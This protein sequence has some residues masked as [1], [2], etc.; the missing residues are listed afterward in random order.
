MDLQA[1]SLGM[2]TIWVVLT[3]AM[4]FLMEGGFA[5][6]EA[7]FVRSKNNVSIIMKVFV[8]MVFGVLAFFAVGFGIMFGVDKLGLFGTNGFALQ[9][10]LEHLGLSVPSEAFWLFQAAFVVAAISIVSGAIAERMNFKAYILFAVV[11][12]AVIYPLSGHWVWGIDGWL[13]KLGMKDFAGS[14]AIHAMAGFAALAAARLVGAR[15]GKFNEDGTVNVIAPSNLPL[16]AMGTFVLWFG[17]F[18]FNAGSTLN[19][20]ASNIGSIAS[21]TLLAS[22]AGG[23]SAM[24]YTLFKTGKADPAFTINGVLAGLVAI[25]AGCAFVGPF[26]ALVIGAFAGVLMIWAT[27][28]VDRMK[29]D[30]PVGAVAVHGFNGAFGAIAVG[31]FA[32]DGGLLT[33]GGWNLLGAQVLGTVVVSVWGY[34]ATAGT[35]KLIDKVVSIRVSV[36]E[37]LAGLDLSYHGTAAYS[38]LNADMPAFPLEVPQIQQGKGSE[39]VRV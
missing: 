22:A 14:A 28:W 19:A 26:S 4:I 13:A 25:T 21:V 6:L 29:V 3:A 39:A 11:M 27:G 20:T 10:S 30:D 24:L 36:E 2:N 35:L 5:L 37:E 17:W 16:A 38:E 33:T 23:A 34:L 31:L 9:G 8:D 18:G 1:L 7:G 15:I 32:I 12:A